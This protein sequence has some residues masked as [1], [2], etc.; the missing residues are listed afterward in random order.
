MVSFLL[1][2]SLNIWQIV[3]ADFGRL[4]LSPFN[5]SDAS[6]YYYSAWYK[7]LMGTNS[8]VSDIIAFSPYERLLSQ[9][10]EL[11]KPVFGSSIVSAFVLNAFLS[12]LTCT[13]IALI[14]WI[15]FDIK[16]AWVALLIYCLSTPILY[17]NGLTVKTTLV[18]FLSN[19]AILFV[20]QFFKRRSIYLA[21]FACAIILSKFGTG[22][23]RRE[24][25]R[26][27]PISHPQLVQ[28]V[29]ILNLHNNSWKTVFRC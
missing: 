16:S 17:F 18:M 21:I 6:L 14:T 9:A 24:L 11:F 12:G 15:L 10:L 28:S 5:F 22:R 4:L 23:F 7:S 26:K 29:S 27:S 20:V 3:A 2:F 19:G 1:S 25:N 13:L 8:F